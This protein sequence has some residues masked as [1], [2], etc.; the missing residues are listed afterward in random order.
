[1][2]YRIRRID[3]FWITHPGVLAAIVLGVLIALGGYVK[4]NTVLLIVGGSLFGLGILA[5]TKP[6]ISLV[7]ASLGLLGGFMTFVVLPSKDLVGMPHTWRLLTTLF[8]MMIYMV[9]IDAVILFLCALYNFFSGFLTVGGG[10]MSLDI[11][12]IEGRE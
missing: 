2:S 11:E 5:A 1:M 4:T 10:G 6:T 8:F 7:I 12:E 9:F 3:P